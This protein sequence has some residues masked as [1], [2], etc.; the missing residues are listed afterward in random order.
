MASSGSGGGAGTIEPWDDP[1]G[2]GGGG[3]SGAGGGMGGGPAGVGGGEPVPGQVFDAGMDP[4][5]NN[6]QVTED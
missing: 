5:L 2:D 3:A 4:A 1:T 6:V